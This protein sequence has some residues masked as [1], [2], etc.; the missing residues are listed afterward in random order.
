ML[1]AIV[2]DIIGSRFEFKP[3]KTSDFVLFSPDCHF[4]D[5]TVLTLATAEA[6]LEKRPFGDL[7]RSFYRKYPKAGYGNRF[8]HWASAPTSSAY[9]SFGNGSAMRVAPVAWACTSLEEVLA[10][11][12]QSAAPT[13]DHPEGIKGAQAVASAIFLAR[14]GA[15]KEKIRNFVEGQFSYDLSRPLSLIRPDYGFEVSCQKSVPEALCC[16]LESDDLVSAVRLAISL[17]GDA[18]TQ[19]AI[20]GSVAEAFYGEVAD[21]LRVLALDYLDSSLLE[22]Y[23]KFVDTYPC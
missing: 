20:A 9:Q 7:Y 15:T 5:D 13:H 1:G 2:G 18:D 17:G 3:I 8:V 12:T 19:A 14:Q 6:L 10:V 4:T 21:D 16:F 22:V 11:A 23:Q